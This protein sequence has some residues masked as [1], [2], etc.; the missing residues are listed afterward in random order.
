MKLSCLSPFCPATSTSRD[1]STSHHPH[2]HHK[3]QR[4]LSQKRPLQSFST[5]K[6]PVHHHIVLL[7]DR[8]S[9]PRS[10]NRQD[11]LQ[12]PQLVRSPSHIAT[13][14]PPLSALSPIMSSS[15]PL[16]T[17]LPGFTTRTQEPVALPLQEVQRTR[18]L[19]DKGSRVSSLN[20]YSSSSSP[21]RQSHPANPPPWLPT[22]RQTRAPRLRVR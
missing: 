22:L 14:S 18:P 4:Q 2:Q 21:H 20:S 3:H 1:S 8:A 7:A 15:L 12:P 9:G 19:L 11:V 5:P 6:H 10:P 13:A 16:T 17:S